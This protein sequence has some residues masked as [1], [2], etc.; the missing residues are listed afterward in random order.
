MVS[1][2]FSLAVTPTGRG[3]DAAKDDELILCSEWTWVGCRYLQHADRRGAPDKR[4]RP[5]Q[6]LKALTETIHRLPFHFDATARVS[7]RG[8]AELIAHN[9]R[10]L[11]LLVVEKNFDTCGP[12][13]HTQRAA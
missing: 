5:Q 4:Q 13:L 11:V 6:R 8:C 1:V 7:L 10:L 9:K 12:T 3:I 2:D